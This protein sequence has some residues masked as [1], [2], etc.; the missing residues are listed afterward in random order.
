MLSQDC[1]SHHSVI[2]SPCRHTKP[3]FN[4]PTP[5]HHPQAPHRKPAPGSQ[6]WVDAIE[7]HKDICN[8][9]GSALALFP[10]PPSAAQSQTHGFLLPSATFV[11]VMVNH[12]VLGYILAY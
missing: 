2:C 1:P 9:A 10:I 6:L 12:Q 3:Q 7:G 8:Y 11:F 5:Q 4:S